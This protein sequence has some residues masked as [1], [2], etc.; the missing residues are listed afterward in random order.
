MTSSSSG[1][2]VV[3]GWNWVSLAFAC[4]RSYPHAII[5]VVGFTHSGGQGDSPGT[6]AIMAQGGQSLARGMGDQSAH[7]A[8]R[9]KRE[10][11]DPPGRVKKGF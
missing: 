5:G 3:W 1:Q 4:P 10:H 6:E 2:Y 8:Q 9:T 7:R 11:E